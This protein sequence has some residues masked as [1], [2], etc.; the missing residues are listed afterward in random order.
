MTIGK[1]RTII[2]AEIDTQ[3]EILS[4]MIEDIADRYQEEALRFEQYIDKVAEEGSDGDRDIKFSIQRSFDNSLEKQ[5][6]LT[7]EARKILFCAIF[8]Y[9]ES[10]LY[11]LIGYY[12]IPRGRTNQVGQLI[13]KIGEEYLRRY[14]KA[15][16][17]TSDTNVL[18]NFYRPLRNMYMHGHIGNPNDKKNLRSYL[19]K[20][21]RVDLVSGYCEIKSNTFLIDTLNIVN[22]CLVEIEEA[23]C[24]KER[25]RNWRNC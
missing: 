22:N 14:S 25:E 20:E 18:S 2:R 1:T 17:F 7:F 12:M 15:L 10:M 4:Q 23:Y 24:K 9:F 8:S 21:N 6:S 5:Y 13:D 19:E 3:Y 11:G 16:S